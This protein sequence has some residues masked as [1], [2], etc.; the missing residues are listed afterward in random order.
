MRDLGAP[1]DHCSIT[2]FFFFFFFFSFRF[3]YYYL[4]GSRLRHSFLT[5]L[6]RS[7]TSSEYCHVFIQ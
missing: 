7:F 5:F 6:S 4:Q 2:F 1:L 3:R